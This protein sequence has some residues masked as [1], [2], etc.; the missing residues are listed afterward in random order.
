MNKREL[1]RLKEIADNSEVGLLPLEDTEFLKQFIE[2]HSQERVETIKALDL[3]NLRISAINAEV[4]NARSKGI[5]LPGE[6]YQALQSEKRALRAEVI[7]LQSK[8]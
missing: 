2:R 4:A 8:L 3:K 1:E 7:E 5:F 6:K